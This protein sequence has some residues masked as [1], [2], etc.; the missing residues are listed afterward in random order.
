[1]LGDRFTS[2]H[3]LERQLHRDGYYCKFSCT[4]DA[5][6]PDDLIWSSD[7]SGWEMRRKLRAWAEKHNITD[8]RIVRNTSWVRDL[9]GIVYELWVPHK[10]KDQ[11]EVSNTN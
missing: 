5:G 11:A 6:A 3:A 4:Y 1:M 8:Y 2:F 10:K 7:D 9:H